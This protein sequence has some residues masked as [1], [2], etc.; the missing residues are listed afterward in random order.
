MILQSYTVV[1]SK[2]SSHINALFFSFSLRF[3]VNDKPKDICKAEIVFCPCSSFCGGDFLLSI[4]AIAASSESTQCDSVFRKTCWF[5]IKIMNRESP[6]SIRRRRVASFTAAFAVT[7]L[8]IIIGVYTGQCSPNIYPHSIFTHT[9]MPF[10]GTCLCGYYVWSG[11]LIQIQIIGVGEMCAVLFCIQIGFS[12]GHK[13][14]Q[15]FNP[16]SVLFDQLEI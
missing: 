16:T 10:L 4:Q 15:K 7:L 13:V 8:L 14:P 1:K 5:L 9:C 3:P 6:S 2:L 12:F 11:E